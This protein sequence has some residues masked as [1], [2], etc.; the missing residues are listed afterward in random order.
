MNERSPKPGPSSR[1]AGAVNQLQGPAKTTKANAKKTLDVRI[2][3]EWVDLHKLE[4][5]STE[6]KVAEVKIYWEDMENDQFQRIPNHARLE[7]DHER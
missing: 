3:P 6:T 2:I 1:F 5:M 4:N 7:R